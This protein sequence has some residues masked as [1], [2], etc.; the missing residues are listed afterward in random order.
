MTLHF[1]SPKSR[2]LVFILFILISLF[3]P[4]HFLRHGLREEETLLRP[5]LPALR[6]VKKLQPETAH[7]TPRWTAGREKFTPRPW[8]STF[9]SRSSSSTSTRRSRTVGCDKSTR[10]KAWPAV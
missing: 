9:S 10:T 1:H 3:F 4:V 6:K 5:K 2:R 8:R 7:V